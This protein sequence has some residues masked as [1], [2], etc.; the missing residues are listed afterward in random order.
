MDNSQLYVAV[1]RVASW[2]GL[3]ILIEDAKGI[4]TNVTINIAYNEILMLCRKLQNNY[5]VG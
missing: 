5:L 2:Q 1:S 4:P 3:K